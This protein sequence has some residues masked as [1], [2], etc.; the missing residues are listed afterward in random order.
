M[1]S[2]VARGV[3]LPCGRRVL[4]LEVWHVRQWRDALDALEERRGLDSFR[5]GANPQPDPRRPVVWLRPV[6]V[7]IHGREGCSGYHR[8]ICG[9]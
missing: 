7:R 8:E 9:G 2:L 3:V 4:S 6:P 5:R 1:T